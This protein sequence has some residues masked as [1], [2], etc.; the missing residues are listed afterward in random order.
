MN[1]DVLAHLESQ[2]AQCLELGSPY[3]EALLLAAAGDV[4]AGGPCAALL[5]NWAG[6]PRKDALAMRFA[7]ALHYAVLSG[8][9]PALAAAYPAAD[10]G[11]SMARVWP[12]ARAFLE[13][14]SV[15]VADFLRSP[16]QTNEVRRSI[17]LLPG[18]LELTSRFDQP[19]DLYELGASA[20]LNQMWDRF[21][22]ETASW[23]WGEGPVRLETEWRGEAPRVNA[24]PEVRTRRAC[25]SA[26]LDLEEPEHRL[27]L[28]AYLWADQAERHTRFE[29]AAALARASR[30]R[31]EAADA[32][33]WLEAELPKR[34]QGGL[35]VVYHSIFYQY[36]PAERRAAIRAAIEAAGAAATPESP[37]AWLRFEPEAITDA[38]PGSQRYL[39]D[40][41]I[42]PGGARRVLATADPHAR[43][44]EAL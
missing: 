36:P 38:I 41:T 23:R 10:P 14:E 30:V 32:A 35:A 42:W 5:G 12:E 29:A 1:P 2:A 21:A 33:A 7:G 20:G 6:P 17:A 31:V 4:R 28:K 16:P 3:M 19:M 43:W 9:A 39:V 22:Y 26:P 15:W 13:R 37:L 34:A 24:R 18:F 40:L 25:D 8:R 44:V 27:R 11:W